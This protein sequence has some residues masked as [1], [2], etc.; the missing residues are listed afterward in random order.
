MGLTCLSTLRNAFC[1]KFLITPQ[2]IPDSTMV[3]TPKFPADGPISHLTGPNDI[4]K[5]AKT[6]QS[7]S[8]CFEVKSREITLLSPPYL[9]LF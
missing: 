9:Y 2:E 7:D 3:S 4:I 8:D 6:L 5:I 1:Y